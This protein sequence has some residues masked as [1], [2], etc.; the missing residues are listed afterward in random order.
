M[1]ECK[2]ASG[3]LDFHQQRYKGVLDRIRAHKETIK[4]QEEIIHNL[5]YQIKAQTE[6]AALVARNLPPRQE[7][8][9]L[10]GELRFKR[11]QLTEK[12]K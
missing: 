7:T 1:E 5:A 10:L 12:L 8:E 2:T 6:V 9:I 3:E 11:E 4:N